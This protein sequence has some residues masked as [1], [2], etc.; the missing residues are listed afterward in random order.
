MIA[1]DAVP[2]KGKAEAEKVVET[3]DAKK[4]VKDSKT[5][6]TE[7]AEKAKAEKEKAA[8]EA[9]GV[10]I[11]ANKGDSGAL[12]PGGKPLRMDYPGTEDSKT[13]VMTTDQIEGIETVKAGDTSYGLRVKELE[14]KI[15]DLKEKVFNS[16]TRIVLLR[17]KL[18]SGNLAGSKAL[19]IHKTELGSAWRLTQ[20]IYNLDG[21]RVFA[22]NDDNGSLADKETFKVYDLGLSPGNH[23]ITVFLKYEGTS[24]GIFPYF[25]GYGGT[26]RASCDVSAKEGKVSR[27]EVRVFPQGGIAESIEKRPFV[28]CNVV[29]IDNIAKDAKPNNKPKD[30]VQ[31]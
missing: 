27:V 15:D 5:E 1:Q 26:M 21:T 23:K 28:E 18:L 4:T 14:T 31:K 22:Q 9:E 30:S 2:E 12:G 17:E 29:H 20:A 3:V 8:K 10:K 11:D 25:E 19:I 16:K 24:M 13:T 6:A 7:A